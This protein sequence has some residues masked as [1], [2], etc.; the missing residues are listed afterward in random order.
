MAATE[1][2]PDIRAESE[3]AN[4]KTLTKAMADADISASAEDGEALEDGEIREEEEE[5]DGKPKTVFDSAT[6]FN[7]KVCLSLRRV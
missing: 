1:A 5:D 2:T 3:A 4:V 6:K 7:L